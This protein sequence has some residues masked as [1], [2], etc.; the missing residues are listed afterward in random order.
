MVYPDLRFKPRLCVLSDEQIQQ[1]HLATLEVLERTGVQITH[2]RAVELLHGAGARVDG[3]R[4]RIPA[5]MVEDAI[6]T[7][8][9]A[10]CWASATVNDRSFWRE[11]K[12]GSGPVWTASITWIQAP[13]SAIASPAT[14][15]AS[16]RRSPT[17]CPTSPG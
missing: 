12:S 7:A 14:I 16:P 6:R 11:K 15:V 1:I 5:W 13:T 17:L 10:W 9:P 4:V 2:P 8:P 3:K